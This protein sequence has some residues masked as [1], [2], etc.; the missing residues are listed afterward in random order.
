MR[1]TR[2]MRSA[3]PPS[4]GTTILRPMRKFLS[5][6][7]SCTLLT[8]VISRSAMQLFRRTRSLGLASAMANSW[9]WWS[10]GVQ[11]VDVLQVL[12]HLVIALD[13]Q[14][15]ERGAGDWSAASMPSVGSMR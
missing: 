1:S 10:V 13:G 7:R 9:Y 5:V 15:L 3:S 2:Y 11:H 14:P 8:E 6:S 4:S 12:L